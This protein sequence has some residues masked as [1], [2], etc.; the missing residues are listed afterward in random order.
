MYTQYSNWTSP[1]ETIIMYSNYTSP[2][3]ET[4]YIVIQSE[5]PRVDTRAIKDRLRTLTI[6]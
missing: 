1:D 6:L 4:I 5:V 2:S 3:D